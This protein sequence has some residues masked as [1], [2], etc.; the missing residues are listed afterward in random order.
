MRIEELLANVVAADKR[1]KAAVA[2]FF[3]AVD[4]A[5]AA[6]Q[7]FQGTWSEAQSR[8]AHLT[9]MAPQAVHHSGSKLF[10]YDGEV[11]TVG[12][13]LPREEWDGQPIEVKIGNYSI[14]QVQSYEE[15]VKALKGLSDLGKSLPKGDPISDL[16]EKYFDLEAQR[17]RVLEYMAPISVEKWL[18]D[19]RC[20]MCP[21]GE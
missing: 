4:Q 6:S 9:M 14:G 18:V 19:G 2:L 1:P 3:Q 7:R 5:C 16:A 15:A 13:N 8:F 12:A 11:Q 21:S 17:N 20:V 10:F